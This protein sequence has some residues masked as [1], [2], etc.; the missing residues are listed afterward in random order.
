MSKR[1]GRHIAGHSDGFAGLHQRG[2]GVGCECVSISLSPSPESGLRRAVQQREGADDLAGRVSRRPLEGQHETSFELY[3]RSPRSIQLTVLPAS[4][5]REVAP[6]VGPRAVERRHTAWRFWRRT[7]LV[8]DP[9]CCLY[10]CLGARTGCAA[11]E[12]QACWSWSTAPELES[13][14]LRQT[15]CRPR[16]L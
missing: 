5:A 11:L 4:A 3:Q 16:R 7:Y 8:K 14:E 13:L 2:L 10:P 6:I 9:Q 1:F 12:V 15:W